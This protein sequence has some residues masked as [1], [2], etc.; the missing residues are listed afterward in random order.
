M[1]FLVVA[2]DVIWLVCLWFGLFHGVNG[3]LN[4]GLFM[5]WLMFVC[6]FFLIKEEVADD[7]MKKKRAWQIWRSTA[8][9]VAGIAMLVWSGWWFTSVAVSWAAIVNAGAWLQFQKKQN[10]PK[11]GG[12]DLMPCAWCGAPKPDEE[13]IIESDSGKSICYRCI[14]QYE[15]DMERRNT[16]GGCA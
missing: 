3:A 1:K 4:I 2:L 14:E 6:S 16:F 10:R 11:D 9:D 7:V 5:A 13:L 15:Q 12:A 8:F